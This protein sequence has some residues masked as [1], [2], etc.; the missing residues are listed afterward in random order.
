VSQI[1]SDPGDARDSGQ[2]SVLPLLLVLA[3][4]AFL[5]WAL[6]FGGL[7]RLGGSQAVAP[8]ASNAPAGQSGTTVNV[9]PTIN[10]RPAPSGDAAGTA[11][12]KP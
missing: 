9:E 2:G 8:A 6:A 11:P 12:S 3:L 7:Q 10:V 1:N 5:V 4:A